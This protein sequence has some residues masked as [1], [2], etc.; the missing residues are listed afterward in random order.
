M[1]DNGTAVTGLVALLSDAGNLYMGSPGVERYL[2]VGVVVPSCGCCGAKWM[3]SFIYSL[4]Q[5]RAGGEEVSSHLSE[6]SS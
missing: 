5:S 3:R 6:L 1:F 4:S 2:A